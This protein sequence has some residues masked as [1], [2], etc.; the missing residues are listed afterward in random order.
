MGRVG[1]RGL[2]VVGLEQ[3]PVR[4]GDQAPSPVRQRPVGHDAQ[5]RH[6]VEVVVGDATVVAPVVA[7]VER[8]LELLPRGEHLAQAHRVGVQFVA[9]VDVV[10]VPVLGH[11]LAEPGQ[12]ELVPV[13][14]VPPRKGIVDR[15]AERVEG[16]RRGHRE[17]PHRAGPQ[18]TGKAAAE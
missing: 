9:G 11:P 5:L 17:D 13:A 3:P 18:V 6:G 16:V 15:H 2:A 4:V 7:Q 8:V 1:D 14:A 10:D 12:G